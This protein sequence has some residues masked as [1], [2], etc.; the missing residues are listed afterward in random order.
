MLYK[1]V[2][3][4]VKDPMKYVYG[5]IPP[6]VLVGNRFFD[7]L[8]FLE[9]SQRWS[10]SELE[11]YQNE[12]LKRLLKH[13]YDNVP[14]YRDIFRRNK[15]VPEDIKNINDLPKLPV[16][17]KEDVRQNLE[18]MRA[19]N[20]RE[21]DIV[22]LS[23]SGTT[24]KPLHFYNEKKLEYLYSDPYMWRFFGWA[25]HRLGDRRATLSAWTIRNGCCKY[26][27][28]R[29][30]L[31]LSIHKMNKEN[32]AEYADA[33]K[34]YGIRY[35]DAYP[36]M[37]V[38]LTMY[39][40]SRG[41]SCPV[42]LKAI[43][44]HS[45]NLYAWQ[46]KIIEAYWSCRCFNWYALE[47]RVIFGLE[48]EKHEGLH[49]CSDFGITEFVDDDETGSKSIIATGLTNYA[50]PFIRYDTGDVGQLSEKRCS[51]G[52]GFPIFELQGGRVRNFAIGKNG[53]LIP[54]DT[55]DIPS[56]TDKVYRFQFV[57]EK[58]GFLDLNIVKKDTFENADRIEIVKQ[59]SEKLGHNMD[60]NV[61]F[62]DAYHQAGNRKTPVFV[63]N[64]Q[65]E[66][67]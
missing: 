28:V 29:R 58:A 2:P 64:I 67:H 18:K 27:P 56:F 51:C 36:G 59:L 8:N 48:C 7:Q 44:C 17:K 40:K 23:T 6:R 54:I 4:W 24:G 1:Y 10:P 21:K 41:I 37:I 60:I 49:L 63:R 32:I 13:A 30:L 61:R 15:L 20:I 46:R 38:L 55:L 19:E 12:R 65:Y 45:E 25:G 50:M 43:F 5:I 26:N 31:V 22:M 39:L 16:L 57:Q 53:A 9:Q 35:I 42:R 52:R 14:Y 34:R 66:H 3:E 62:V 47:E 33:L 11:E